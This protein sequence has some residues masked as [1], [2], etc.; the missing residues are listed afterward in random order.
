V[1]TGDELANVDAAVIDLTNARRQLEDEQLRVLAT[2]VGDHALPPEQVSRLQAVQA[3][4][5][6]VPPGPRRH[7]R[8]GPQQRGRARTTRSRCR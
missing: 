5:H 6:E 7:S 8:A 1:T 3:Q 4:L 2:A